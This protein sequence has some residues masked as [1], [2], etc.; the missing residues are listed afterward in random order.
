MVCTNMSVLL[1][2]PQPRRG[3]CGE[4]ASHVLH[5]LSIGFCRVSLSVL[6]YLNLVQ[7]FLNLTALESMGR[8]RKHLHRAAKCVAFD[9][10]LG[11]SDTAARPP[12]RRSRALGGFSHLCGCTYHPRIHLSLCVCDLHLNVRVFADFMVSLLL[13][14]R[15]VFIALAS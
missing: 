13:W 9:G 10:Y 11:G 15:L 7:C 8:F 1:R 5:P 6:F 14:S 12:S 2:G 4:L 3:D